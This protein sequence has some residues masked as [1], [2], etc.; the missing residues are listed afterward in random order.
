MPDYKL[1]EE[2]KKRIRPCPFCGCPPKG[3]QLNDVFWIEC[4]SRYGK[5]CVCPGST[6]EKNIEKCIPLWN[7]RRRKPKK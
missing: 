4:S 7:T 3:I 1:T 6:H 5:E 2:Q